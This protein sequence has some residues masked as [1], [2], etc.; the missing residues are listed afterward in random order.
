MSSSKSANSSKVIRLPIPEDG[1]CAGHPCDNCKKCVAGRCCRQD[2]PSYVLPEVGS[3]PYPIHG[4]IGSLDETNGLLTCH[5]CGYANRLLYSHIRV[6]DVTAAEYRAYF[7]LA[8]GNPLTPSD[9]RNHLRDLA[10]QRVKRNPEWFSRFQ[11]GGVAWNEEWT[12][13]RR[14]AMFAKRPVRPE[15]RNSENFHIPNG[16]EWPIRKHCGRGHELT[17][18]NTID[19]RSTGRGR[20]CRECNRE[21]A[22]KR[23][24]RIRAERRG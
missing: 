18:D 20:Q 24:A 7:G 8:R 11:A 19:R 2:N 4:A 16:P 13:E 5:I 1:C 9:V 3:W 21:T 22:R 10:K 15:V 23:A 14:H 6:H 12:P 17:S